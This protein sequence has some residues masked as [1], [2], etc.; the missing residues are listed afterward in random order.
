MTAQEARTIADRT[1]FN[2]TEILMSIYK[3]IEEAA[4][5]GLSWVSYKNPNVSPLAL[6]EVEKELIKK[7]YEISDLRSSDYI[8]I[9]W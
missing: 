7:G 9:E 4:K 2:K 5:K 3:G 1:N 8:Q 6:E